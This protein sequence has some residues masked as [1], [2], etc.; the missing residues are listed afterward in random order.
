MNNNS[1][2]SRNH[3]FIGASFDKSVTKPLRKIQNHIQ[4]TMSVRH[5]VNQFHTRF[6]YLGYLTDDSL[7]EFMQYINPAMMALAKT[8]APIRCP[9][10]DFSVKRKSN[11]KKISVLYSSS[12]V[13]YVI[14]PYLRNYVNDILGYPKTGEY[15]PHVNLCT[16][17]G[18]VEE[19]PTTLVPEYFDI[20]SIDI[21]KGV[22]VEKRSGTPSKHDT[23]NIYKYRSIPFVGTLAERDLRL[24]NLDVVYEP[25]EVA[26]EVAA[27][28]AVNAISDP[29]SSSMMDSEHYLS[30]NA[31]GTEGN[32]GNGAA[33]NG[34]G[35]IRNNGAAANG[36]AANGTI[37]NNGAVAANGTAAN[38]TI[39][40]NGAVAANG[41][42]AETIP[43]DLIEEE[44]PRRNNNNKRPNNKRL[45][46]NM[47][48]ESQQ[49]LPQPQPRPVNTMNFSG[50]FK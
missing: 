10:G 11:Y 19:L 46:N 41:T 30:Y 12:I 40:N 28:V 48:A 22:P 21:L 24:K 39:R 35:T 31:A 45:N 7:E 49:A 6:V 14:V 1:G 16:V 33:A 25:G 32:G 27:N 5:T 37:R 42:V 23:M 18:P 38:G 26:A 13:S 43:M 2:S 29:V 17:K 4:R 34:N 3:Y 8:F 15:M 9:F 47:F 36:T 44:P 20:R 50:L